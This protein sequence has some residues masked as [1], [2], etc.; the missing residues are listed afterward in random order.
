[1]IEYLIAIIATLMLGV[2]LNSSVRIIN[3]SDQAIVER[4]GQYNRTLT[5]G[6]RIVL[7]VIEKVVYYE[8]IRERLLDIPPQ[9][10]LTQES[11]ELTIDA[12][13]YWKVEKLKKLY[14]DVENVDELMADFVTN[15]LRAEVGQRQLFELL[16]SIGKVDKAIL[17]ALDEVTPDWGIKVLRVSIQTIEPPKSVTDAR[18]KEKAAESIQRAEILEAES[19]AKF[20]EVLARVMKMEPNSPEFIKFLIAKQY[21]TANEE[22]SKSDN[23]KII[24]MHP[25]KLTEEI[26]NLMEQEVNPPNS[27]PNPPLKL[28]KSNGEALNSDDNAS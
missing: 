1:M 20:I 19:E 3:E 7:P 4:L 18:E 15:T 2:S 12:A 11:I 13:V 26:V 14:Y 10:V 27:N 23:S 21:V 16:A 24:F 9:K 22:L 8:T 5:S 17:K 6:L 28:I 25:E